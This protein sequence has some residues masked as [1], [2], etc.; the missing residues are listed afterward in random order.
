MERWIPSKKL[1]HEHRWRHRHRLF[2]AHPCQPRAADGR[3]PHQGNYTSFDGTARNGIARLNADG[4][5]DTAFD[6]GT[7]TDS[8]VRAVG[9]RTDGTVV[10][11]GGFTTLN[12]TA[13]SGIARL[14]GT[15][16]IDASSIQEQASVGLHL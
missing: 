11:G 5:L 4:T 3:I 15:G 2:S 16:A 10:I 1:R 8:P 14:L 12:S 9:L 6:P 7:G 13:K